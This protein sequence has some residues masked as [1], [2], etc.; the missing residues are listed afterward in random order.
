M[1]PRKQNLLLT[2]PR[3]LA[4]LP[5]FTTT[6]PHISVATFNVNSLSIN[7]TN[8]RSHKARRH[9]Y[10]LRSINTL[11][12]DHLLLC[13]QETHLHPHDYVALKHNLPD[14]TIYYNNGTEPRAGT[15]II[16]DNRLHTYFNIESTT[17]PHEHPGYMQGLT[18]TPRRHHNEGGTSKPLQLFNLYLPND[19]KLKRPIFKTLLSFPKPNPDITTILVGDLNFV[20]H[21]EDC[22]PPSHNLALDHHTHD[23]WTK[24]LKKY[25]LHEEAQ[26]THTHYFIT[27][28]IL[29]TRTSRIDKIFTSYSTAEEAII[30]PATYIPHLNQNKTQDYQRLLDASTPNTP[31]S[32]PLPPSSDHLPVGLRFAPPPSRAALAASKT[33]HPYAPKWLADAPGAHPTILQL[34]AKRGGNIGNPYTALQRWK[35]AVHA[36][37]RAYYKEIQHQKQLATAHP[38]TLSAAIRLYQSCHAHPYNA[39]EVRKLLHNTPKLAPYISSPLTDHPRPNTDQL[40][41]YITR[42]II[43]N[44]DTHN[45]TNNEHHTSN[46]RDTLPPPPRPLT[47]GAN[48]TPLVQLKGRIPSA[49]KGLRHLRAS[50]GGPL[51][52]DSQEMGAIT[53]AAY[54]RIWEKGVSPSRPQLRAYLRAYRRK[55]SS[56]DRAE[57]AIPTLEALAESIRDTNNSSPGPDG[58]PFAYY[59]LCAEELAPVLHA[60][61]SELAAGNPPPSGYNHALLHLLPKDN[62]YEI[63]NTRPISVTNA[64]NRILAKLLA[65]IMG[66]VLARVLHPNQKGFIPGRVG[67]D[68]IRTLTQ[69]YYTAL[70]TKQ[71]YFILFLDTRKAFDSIHHDF[72]HATLRKLHIPRWICNVVKGFLT[73]PHALPTFARDYSIAIEKG[74]KQGCPLSPLLFAICYDVLLSLLDFTPGH[75]SLA[76]ADDLASGAPQLGTLLSLLGRITTF[77]RHSR[78]GLNIH[79]TTILSSLPPTPG[80]RGKL[81]LFWPKLR[82]V[83]KATYLGVL[84]GQT[85]TTVEIFHNAMSKFLFR[86]KQLHHVV[87]PATLHQR[88]PIYN[89]YLLPI[90]LYLAQLYIIPYDEIIIPLREHCRKAII[91]YNGGAF[92]YALLVSPSRSS[93]GPFTPLRDLWAQNMALLASGYDLS[94]SHGYTTPQ[95]GDMQHVAVDDEEDWG[96]LLVSEH[97]A[98]AAY[99]FLCFYCPRTATNRLNT[100]ALNPDTSHATR[101][102]TM[103][104]L[105]ADQGYSTLRMH[106]TRPA[107]LPKKLS[108]SRTPPLTS[109]CT[110]LLALALTLPLLPP[111]DPL[112][113]T[114]IFALSLTR[115]PLIAASPPP[116]SPPHLVASTLV[117]H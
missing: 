31:L 107:T 40:H 11:L 16:V 108:T 37:T 94:P 58:I 53:Q 105:M 52:N 1:L 115:S 24:V 65:R 41:K 59:R 91:P 104:R 103:Y 63:N 64:D 33:R 78:L 20:D 100:S 85:I 38:T 17:L 34:W 43:N 51:T 26:P 50:A 76:F 32:N 101:R 27:N 74:V 47:G 86:A 12:S 84:M 19:H 89:T 55:L 110:V 57:L 73:R 82:F 102:R 79:K 72:I 68:H 6:I 44:V 18:L 48:R 3:R 95:L 67:L 54:R 29:S 35:E 99:S 71:K 60:I 4:P 39:T 49:R 69:L 42:L 56:S 30:H 80:E 113:G 2:Q 111:Y 8:P 25:H 14:H 117:A 116:K 81:Q 15:L 5:S 22:S 70:D 83:S 46:E 7:P 87:K 13:L 98:H 36:H 45:H 23:I 66:P 77:S 10:V 97:E 61:L 109:A 96:S 9:R 106:R 90:M 114:P 112:P 88:I 62:S 93:I 21:P 28:D 92:S 75:T